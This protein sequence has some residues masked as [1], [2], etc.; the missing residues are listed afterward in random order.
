MK[1]L[2]TYNDFCNEEINLR[3]AAAGAALGLGL[4]ISNPVISQNSLIKYLML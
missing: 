1:N 3:K 2:K 4:A